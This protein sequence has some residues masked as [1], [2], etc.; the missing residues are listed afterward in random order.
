[1]A[2]KRP[3]RKNLVKT[4]GLPVKVKKASQSETHIYGGCLMC[5]VGSHDQC[6]REH[7]KVSQKKG[8]P[9]FTLIEFCDCQHGYHTHP[10][11][12]E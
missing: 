12:E 6:A 4:G 5:K 8:Q 2:G 9:A 7:R 3:R 10:S 1:M 11:R